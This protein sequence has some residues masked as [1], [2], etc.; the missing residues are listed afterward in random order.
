MHLRHPCVATPLDFAVSLK[1]REL[2]IAH[3]QAP[4]DS[5]DEVL[6]TSPLWWTATVKSIAIVG[7]V[8]GM[9]FV[10]SFGLVCG[11]LKPSNILF[12]ESH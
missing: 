1:W 6:Q 10:H 3:K 2:N 8:L 12:D 4:I 9:R 7:I 5:L 11:N